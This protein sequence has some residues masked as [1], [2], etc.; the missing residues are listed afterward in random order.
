[1][2]GW[3]KMTLGRK[4]ELDPKRHC[5]RWGPSSPPSKRG[6]SLPPI[7]ACILWP[8]GWMDQDGTGYDG[9]QHVGNIVLDADPAPPPPFLTRCGQRAGWI[10][11][12]VGTNVGV[13]PR[14][15]V[16]WEPA[17]PKGAEPPIFDPGLLWPNS[18]LS[19]L[20]LSTCIPSFHHYYILKLFMY[21]T[22]HFYFVYLL[23]HVSVFLSFNTW[24]LALLNM[25]LAHLQLYR[26]YQQS[27]ME[28]LI[29]SE[30]WR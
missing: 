27:W 7:N 8:N 30:K 15:N 11:M 19:Q 18:R 24:T 23:Q 16:T 25:T 13:G 1:M 10:K 9:R 22:C 5:A 21:V 3:I 4:V 26:I 29:L 14:H 12:P 17:P 2:A 6:H 20:L 28:C